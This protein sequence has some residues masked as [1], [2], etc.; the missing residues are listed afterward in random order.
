M[1]NNLLR[2]IIEAGDIVMFI[3]DIMIRRGT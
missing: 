2:D 1:I 3:D